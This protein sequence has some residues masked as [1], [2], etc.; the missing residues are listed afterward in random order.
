MLRYDLFPC[1]YEEVLHYVHG[2]GIQLVAPGMQNA[3]ESAMSEAIENE[4]YE[5]LS[6][7]PIEDYDEEYL[8]MGLECYF[9]LW[10]HDPSGD[11][12]CG[13]Q[14]YAFIDRETMA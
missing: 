10:Q 6:D 4:Y 7:L 1:W 2:Y 12:Y 5:P 8:A 11:G 14:E 3:I 9:G 13:D